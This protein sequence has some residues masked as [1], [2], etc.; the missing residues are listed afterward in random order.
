MPAEPSNPPQ[1]APRLPA[2][3]HAKRGEHARWLREKCLVALRG[4]EREKS[5]SPTNLNESMSYVFGIGILIILPVVWGFI[6][7]MKNAQP[8]L[9]LRIKNWH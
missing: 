5:R 7:H 1:I 3:I 4:R 6:K 9:R 8:I 2:T